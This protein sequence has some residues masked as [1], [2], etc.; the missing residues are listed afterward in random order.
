MKFPWKKNNQ[1]SVFQ[2]QQNG[3]V[4]SHYSCK[5]HS[6]SETGP[7]RT[8]NEDSIRWFYPEE[9]LQTLFGMVADGMGGHQAGEIASRLACDAAEEYI[10]TQRGYMNI[11]LMLDGCMQAAQIAIVNAAEENSGYTGMGTT[12]TMIFIR[13]GYMHYAHIGDSRLY[14]FRNQRL[15]QCSSDNTLV[16]EMVSEG[17]ITPEEATT[18]EMKHVLTQ[19]LG[20]VKE[21]RP[22]L[23]FD[24]VA[25][26]AGDIFFIC[27]DG[28]YDVLQPLE[29][30]KLLIMNCP[31][32]AVE[33]M[34]ALCTS[35]KASDN[36]SI[37]LAEI[38]NL[39]Q[40]RVP[41]T[42]ELNSM[43]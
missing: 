27:S 29:I 5:V 16:N 39:Q 37:I 38:T 12:A 2:H 15:I 9:D 7:T 43:I 40:V 10:R 13:D 23:S 26:E 31:E 42:K 41:V 11:P 24:G 35:R 4:A 8:S 33:C 18:H 28:I 6:V 19:A 21:I 32:L 3:S 20:T 1:R 14:H 36:F 17:K 34:T 22:E 30:E 25:I